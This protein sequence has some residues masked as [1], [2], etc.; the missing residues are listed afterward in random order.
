MNTEQKMAA[1]IYD[2]IAPICKGQSFVVL[3]EA[4]NYVRALFK[5][6][7]VLKDPDPLEVEQDKTQ[8][9]E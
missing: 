4:L 9:P 3:D 2:A 8:R 7:C 1:D 6:E 5:K